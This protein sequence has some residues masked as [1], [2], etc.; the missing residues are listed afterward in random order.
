MVVWT[1]RQRDE[2]L[3]RALESDLRALGAEAR[4]G[5]DDKACSA[6]ARRRRTPNSRGCR[7]RDHQG[8]LAR[9]RGRHRRSRR[10]R[11]GARRPPPL[12]FLPERLSL[13]PLPRAS[14]T[15]PRASIPRRRSSVPSSWR[16][17]RPPR[18]SP[19]SACPACRNSRRTT[20]LPD[21]RPPRWFAPSARRR[22]PPRRTVHLRCLQASLTILQSIT[23]CPTDPNAISDLIAPVS[24]RR[25][26]RGRFPRSPPR[27]PSLP[28]QASRRRRSPEPAPTRPTRARTTLPSPTKTPPHSR[29]CAALLLSATS[30]RWR[31]MPGTR[32][33]A[34]RPRLRCASLRARSR[35][36][37]LR[38][39]GDDVAAVPACVAR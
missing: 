20:R 38:R 3:S 37:A 25:A 36:N 35:R 24:P 1:R 6:R 22:T 30:A 26:P 5:E 13:L 33:A 2:R 11:R 28:S 9:S 34:G 32:L 29:E 4:R 23:A 18:P 8:S 19:R 21:A 10:G 14:S 17:R 12:P 27:D 16:A 15:L 39:R 31:R 7:A